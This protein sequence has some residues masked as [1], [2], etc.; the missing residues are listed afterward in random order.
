M[1]HPYLQPSDLATL[2][3]H[4]SSHGTDAEAAHFGCALPSAVPQPGVAGTAG[5]Q[6]TACAR[7]WLCRAGGPP[8]IQGIMQHETSGSG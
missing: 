5:K 2:T 7:C 1:P 8:T 4:A 6:F 3:L